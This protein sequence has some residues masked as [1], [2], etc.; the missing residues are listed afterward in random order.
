MSQKNT[1]TKLIF[2]FQIYSDLPVCW[3]PIF[4]LQNGLGNLAF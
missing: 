1:S 4:Q 3:N 2:I